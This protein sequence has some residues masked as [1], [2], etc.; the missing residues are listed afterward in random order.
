[1]K[2]FHPPGHARS[3]HFAEN[4]MFLH[5]FFVKLGP[6]IVPTCPNIT[7]N[8]PNIDSRYGKATQKM[9]QHSARGGESKPTIDAKHFTASFWVMSRLRPMLRLYGEDI[10]EPGGWLCRDHLGPT[11]GHLGSM[12]RDIVGLC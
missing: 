8:R 2:R 6:K 11:L 10:V 3:N 9:G 7:G 12:L 1:M 4:A 5:V